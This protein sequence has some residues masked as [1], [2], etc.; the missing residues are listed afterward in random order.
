MSSTTRTVH[1]GP[2]P[3][4][5]GV[6]L[7]MLVHGL[8]KL[9]VG[10]LANGAGV[11]GVAGFFGS[12]G[13]PAPLAFAW[14]VTLV[15]AGGGLLLL[16]GLLT[17]YAAALV[18]VDMA[19]ATVLV[20]LPNGFGV[21]TGGYEFTLLLTLAAVSVVLSGPGRLSLEYALF[22]RELVPETLRSAAVE[23]EQERGRPPAV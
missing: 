12:L 22:G 6:G 3:L 18:A 23:E 13:I 8:G 10:P 16:L 14:L 2:L 4:R 17:R 7:V 5:V 9:D 21:S 11:L 1:W 20:H 19:V 15:E